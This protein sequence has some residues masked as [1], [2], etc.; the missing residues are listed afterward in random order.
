[1]FKA[2]FELAF[3]QIESEMNPEEH[4]QVQAQV[5]R[6]IAR[7]E[8]HKEIVKEAEVRTEAILTPSAF[9]KL[10]REGFQPLNGAPATL[11][12]YEGRPVFTTILNGPGSPAGGWF[13]YDPFNPD[14]G[15]QLWMVLV[16]SLRA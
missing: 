1:M 4:S 5:A 15:K 13:M 10:A 2:T 16:L 11:G 6:F 14:A 9:P 12:E 7:T 3:K 8:G